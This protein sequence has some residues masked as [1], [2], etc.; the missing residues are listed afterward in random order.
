MNGYSSD[1]IQYVSYIKE[2]MYG[3]YQMIFRSFPFF[4]PITPIHFIY[5]ATGIVGDWIGANAPFMFHL[6]RVIL[7]SLYVLFT[8]KLF[9]RVFS[10]QLTFLA[11]LLAFISAPLPNLSFFNFSIIHPERITDRPHYVFGAV[12]FLAILLLRKPA[13]LFIFSILTAMVHVSTGIL[14]FVLSLF[15]RSVPVALGSS[16]ALGVTYIFIRKYTLVPEIWL[17][18]YIYSGSITLLGILRDI[19]S[20]GPTLWLGMVGFIL[21]RKPT[22]RKIFYWLLIQLGL[23]LFGY[24]FF[25]AD[26][27]RFLQGLYFIPMAYGTVLFWKY[28]SQKIS[29]WMLP[30]GVFAT[31]L[32][33]LPVYISDLNKSLYFLTDYKNYS[34]FVFPTKAQMESFEYLDKNTPTESLIIG[35]YE[36]ANNLLLYSHNYTL[37]NDQG[38]SKEE[39]KKM[40]ADRD[41]FFAGI[42]SEEEAKQYLQ[43]NNVSFVYNGPKYPFLRPVF[44]NSQV[45]IYEYKR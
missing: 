26:R 33:S 22:H 10:P 35:S 15:L 12:L 31:I 11:T 25:H 8:Y 19:V 24:R 18:S 43:N 41:K 21:D 7:G 2:G 23:F 36:I 44:E 4:Q 1:Y 27:V 28:I 9:S 3:R 14:L 13:L 32:V 6:T 17:D 30:V 16:V 42:L 45:T 40:L 5:I 37:G 38:W 20:F 29:H 39:G 34:T